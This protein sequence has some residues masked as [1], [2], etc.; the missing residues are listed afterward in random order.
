MPSTNVYEEDRLENEKLTPTSKK[1]FI[2]KGLPRNEIGVGY[3]NIDMLCAMKQDDMFGGGM[4]NSPMSQLAGSKWKGGA[5]GLVDNM[6]RFIQPYLYFQ[7]FWTYDIL[8]KLCKYTNIYEY[9]CLVIRKWTPI[10]VDEM[11][12]FLGG[13]IMM[14]LKKLSSYCL[15]WSKKLLWRT[16]KITRTMTRKR[17]ET[18]IKCWH[19]VD[20]DLVVTDKTH[21]EY[22]PVAKIEWLV[23]EHN[24]LY[25]KYWHP[26]QNLTVDEMIVRYMGM[27]SPIRQYLKTK[28]CRYGL[29]CWALANAKSKFV[30]K[31][32]V[33]CGKKE[34][35]DTKDEALVGYKVVMR[36]LEGLEDKGHIV[37]CDDFFTSPILFWDLMLKRD[38][39]NM[40]YQDQ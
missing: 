37:T 38:R 29:K 24:S 40:Y 18:I 35:L 27:W 30:Q 8:V 20:N 16:L 4:W 17:Y 11:R 33:N 28:P 34:L 21:L 2:E 5:T 39:C 14:G 26:K 9:T 19:L 1:W 6:K 23:N 7:D 22:S 12:V 13:C 3:D 32:E 25:A 10:C 31:L 15:H 36:L